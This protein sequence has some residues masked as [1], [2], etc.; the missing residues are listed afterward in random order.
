[1]RVLGGDPCRGKGESNLFVRCLY[2]SINPP[3]LKMLFAFIL[4]FHRC[5]FFVSRR[6]APDKRRQKK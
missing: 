2:D 4:V 6:K 3:K 5:R 1:V